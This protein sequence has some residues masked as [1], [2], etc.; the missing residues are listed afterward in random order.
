MNIGRKS[1]AA[2]SPKWAAFS[3]RFLRGKVCAV[4]GSAEKLEAHH[5]Q[6]FHL[7][8]E[9]ELDESNLLPLCEGRGTLNC[10]LWCGHLGRWNRINNTARED[11]AY[12]GAKVRG[13][14]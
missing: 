10:H 2:R 13:A 11:A 6:P 8:P 12:F 9:L 4:C 5:I 3:K 14:A 7:H 1:R